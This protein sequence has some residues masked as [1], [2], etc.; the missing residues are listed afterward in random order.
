MVACNKDARE[1]D[2]DYMTWYRILCMEE[3]QNPAARFFGL[4]C[5][6]AGA[7][8]ASG[9][10]DSAAAAAIDSSSAVWSISKRCFCE[11]E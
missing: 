8:S 2:K 7:A 11:R 4:A 3:D 5:S 1:G 10:P 6:G 9:A